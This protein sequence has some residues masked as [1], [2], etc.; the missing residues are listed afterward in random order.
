IRPES[1]SLWEV[2]LPL[3]VPGGEPVGRLTIRRLLAEELPLELR[4][5]VEEMV[6]A[7]A[8]GL[9]SNTDS[10]GRMIA[11]GTH[12]LAGATPV[13]G[14]GPLPRGPTAAS[15]PQDFASRRTQRG[16]S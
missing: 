6:P 7:V 2:N 13:G 15:K 12:G 14:F 11:D 4:V 8:Q 1:D 9:A 5:I 16:D 10:A 3:V